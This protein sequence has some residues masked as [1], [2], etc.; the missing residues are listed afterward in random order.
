MLGSEALLDA[1]FLEDLPNPLDLDM[2]F[3]Q[4]RTH[5]DFKYPPL[6]AMSEDEQA[7]FQCL[8]DEL[9]FDA[10]DNTFKQNG[11]F[12]DI[13]EYGGAR[14]EYWWS[15]PGDNEHGILV[16]FE[17]GEYTRIGDGCDDGRRLDRGVTVPELVKKEML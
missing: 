1:Q 13:F 10:D 12:L 2:H 11:V 9:C 16:R 3:L 15:Y 7:G 8:L 4:R 6:G 14:Y 17:N 5:K